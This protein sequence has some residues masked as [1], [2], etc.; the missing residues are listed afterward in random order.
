MVR[1]RNKIICLTLLLAFF[2]SMV[3]VAPASAATVGLVGDWSFDEGIGSLADDASYYVN[4]G[5]ISGGK[6]GNALYFDGAD[7]S[8]VVSNSP[9]LNIA[10]ATTLE[11]W[12]KVDEFPSGRDLVV[13]KSGAYALQISEMGKVRLFLGDWT[14]Y[15]QSS[16]IVLTT[17]SWYHIAGTFDGTYVRIWVNGVLKGEFSL[18]GTQPTTANDVWIGGFPAGGDGA[19]KGTIDEVRIS[20]VA[21]Y[22][23]GF[24]APSSAF[25]VDADTAALWHFDESVG[26][27]AFDETSNNNYGTING[28]VWAGP[29]WTSGI[30]GTTALH[31]DGTDDY[32]RIPDAAS[33][34]PDTVSVEC[35]VRSINP[36]P[37]SHIVSKDFTTA[38]G[39]SSYALYTSGNGGLVFYVK[40]PQGGY[41]VSPNAG[42]ALWN[43]QWQHVV[44]TFD[45]TKPRLF[46]NGIEVVG[47]AGIATDIDYSAAGNLLIGKYSEVQTHPTLDFCFYG[48]IDGVKV[49]NYA[50]NDLTLA[51][52]PTSDA[53][54]PVD[55]AA[56]IRVVVTDSLGNTVEG[57]TVSL[58]DYTGLTLSS[59]SG[60][61]NSNGVFAFTAKGAAVGIYSVTAT[62]STLSGDKTD[63]WTLAIYD[64]SA[65][66]VTGGGWIYSPAGACSADVTLEGKA[67]FGFVSKYEKGATV[68]T[69]GTTFV[70]H[71]AGLEF[72]STSYQWLIVAGSKAQFKGEG[73]I[74]DVAGFGFMLTA[75][76][77][78]KGGID[79]FRIK[80]WE[81][82]GDIV[83]D[84]LLGADDST[85]PTTELGGGNIV[86]H[87]K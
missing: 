23:S 10:G 24:T 54:A 25:D 73:T 5:I 55:V 38:F 30:S 61:T 42:S 76:D 2:A 64:P 9:S 74:N 48:D 59:A 77:G 75:S 87:T 37:Y 47:S 72:E 46:V 71:A 81:I 33:L 36:G 53:V 67:T 83:Y 60:Q 57:V 78:G 65:G 39:A 50:L 21:R 35:W 84:N 28:A 31:F 79:T 13:A 11:A 20:T 27:T 86:V 41:A 69:G 68:P 56:N 82:G 7:D 62:I 14:N 44:G 22:S 8:I 1:F 45:G 29:T 12:V 52:D 40:R 16:S 70:F 80:I 3:F 85:D 6:F 66:F 15:V 63:T 26:N 18:P 34:E 43:G 49:Y 58:S 17:G 32:V 19:F 51:F 4:D